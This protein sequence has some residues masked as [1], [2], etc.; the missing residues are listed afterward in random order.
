[1][2]G[3][4]VLAGEGRVPV[5]ERWVGSA[6]RHREDGE[7]GWC[8]DVPKVTKWDNE[9]PWGHWGVGGGV[10]GGS[11]G[12]HSRLGGLKGFSWHR[13]AH[14]EGTHSHG[15][16]PLPGGSHAGEDGEEESAEEEEGAGEPAGALTAD[17]ASCDPGVTGRTDGTIP[18]L[19][20]PPGSQQQP[21]G[22]GP[23]LP[24]HN[25]RTEPK[26]PLGHVGWGQKKSL[27]PGLH[28]ALSPHLSPRPAHAT[29][30]PAP[31]PSRGSPQPRPHL[32]F[33]Y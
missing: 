23:G 11:R 32:P 9:G 33:S 26:L 28:V 13:G 31:P 8:Q 17:G 2:G 30:H 10:W 5:T 24:R 22:Q 12:G 15:P 14:G 27:V 3:C 6:K 16:D 29:T 25:P 19:P 21:R 18:V 1:M 7:A 4:R 20:E